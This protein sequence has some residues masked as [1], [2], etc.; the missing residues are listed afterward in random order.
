[1]GMDGFAGRLTS[2][3]SPLLLMRFTF[4]K[5]ET[6]A[7]DLAQNTPEERWFDE[8]ITIGLEHLFRG[9]DTIEHNYL[10]VSQI[11]KADE[12]GVRP[13][14]HPREIQIHRRGFE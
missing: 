11:K 12:R 6:C 2:E 5:Q 8:R 7:R 10:S 9:L 13:L 4:S 1:M 14:S 3:E